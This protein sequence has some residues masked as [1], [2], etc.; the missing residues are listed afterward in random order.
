MVVGMLGMKSAYKYHITNLSNP[1]MLASWRNTMLVLE[2]MNKP[3]ETCLQSDNL[4]AA[5]E[6][7][8]KCDCGAIPAINNEGELVGIVTDRDICM[9]AYFKGMPLSRI[10][11]EQVMAKIVFSCRENDTLEKVEE[12]MSKNQIRRVPIVDEFRKPIGVLSLNDIARHAASSDRKSGDIIKFTKTLA[13][14][15]RPRGP[16]ETDQAS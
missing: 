16:Q 3:V 14:V 10:S 2:I 5:A 7:M 13:S 8:W 1:S 4:S 12:L 6:K 15:C 11:V 9:A